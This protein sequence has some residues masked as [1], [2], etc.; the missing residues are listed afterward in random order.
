MKKFKPIFLYRS[1][2]GERYTQQFNGKYSM[3]ESKMNPKYE[4]NYETLIFNGFVDSDKWYK[5]TG[6][7]RN[8][9]VETALKIRK[10][11]VTFFNQ[12]LDKH[13][14]ISKFAEM[15]K[16]DVIKAAKE[17]AKRFFEVLSKNNEKTK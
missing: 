11:A 9:L 17:S 10:D 2:D 12:E 3:D 7:D 6:E 16:K 8:A 14:P 5:I 1:S 15:N 4:Y 13:D